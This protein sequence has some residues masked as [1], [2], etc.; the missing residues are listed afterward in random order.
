MGVI[1]SKSE[2]M[3]I[4]FNAQQISDIRFDKN[5]DHVL[6]PMTKADLPNMKLSRFKW[7]MDQRPKSK[8]E[9]FQ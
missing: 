6:S 2:R 5:P 8:E 3:R 7:L 4:F 9:L 1:E